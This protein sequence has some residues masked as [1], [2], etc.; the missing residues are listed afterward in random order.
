[1]STFGK[2]YNNRIIINGGTILGGISG[3][4]TYFPYDSNSSA[5]DIY[6]NEIIVNGGTI[7]FVSGGDIAFTYD[8]SSSSALD[9]SAER[10]L[11]GGNVYNN[12][13][14]VNG[15]VITS[16][17][18]GGSALT[19]S[20]TDNSISINDGKVSG[21]VVA[22]E[23][24][25]P[26]ANSTVTGNV[27]NIG[28]PNN[29]SVTP[30]LSGATLYGGLMGGNP[31][32]ND[33]TLNIYSPNVTAKNIDGFGGVNFFVQ[34]SSLESG[35]PILTLTSGS[36]NLELN[37]IGVQ[38]PGDSNFQDGDKINLIYNANGLNSSTPTYDATITKGVTSIYGLTLENGSTG[39]NGTVTSKVADTD[40]VTSGNIPAPVIVPEI[41]LPPV[42]PFPVDNE[43]VGN[44]ASDSDG[45]FMNS[46]DSK[47]QIAERV[48][49]TRGY[50]IY[51]NSGGGRLKTKTGGDTYVRAD[52]SNYD[53]GMARTINTKSGNVNVA[54]VFEYNHGNYESKLKNGTT[55]SGNTKYTAGG[56][57][58]R[59]MNNSGF[60]IEGSFRGGR[61]ENEFTADNFKVNDTTQRVSYRMSAPL[62]AG[63]IRLGNFNRIDRN[64]VLE[65]YGIYAYSRQSGM[66]SDL[67]SGEHV[68]FG[69]V[70]SNLER[71]GYRLTTRT[72]KVSR[73]YTGLAFQHESNSGSTATGEDW[74]SYSSGIKGSSGM[75]EIGWQFKPVASVPWMIDAYA[76]GWV[77]HQHGLTAMAKV[78]KAF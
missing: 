66:D 21:L 12:G 33:N 15:G 13:V 73:I 2:V 23:V 75:I 41:V 3:G 57:V 53:I 7:N 77:G 59:S 48:Q 18:S 60:Y 64:N 26:T 5:G 44:F 49:E 16:G 25:Y 10:F 52:S 28:N 19:G 51:L 54:P 67:S 11:T 34:N 14:E 31:T 24:R 45:Y 69:S 43:L 38:V 78:K 70:H 55:G 46:E 58:V 4:L 9:F 39:I 56:L 74:T 72:S 1:M 40:N 20:A 61:S 76:T 30:D 68:R 62:Y 36:T 47:A 42:V 29:P 71:I 22:G 17:I 35:T 8:S 63:H 37:T 65:I 50:S 6:G 27:I 32:A